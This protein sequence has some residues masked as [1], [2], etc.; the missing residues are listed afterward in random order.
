MT[1]EKASTQLE[2]EVI[3]PLPTGFQRFIPG[4][5]YQCNGV[6]VQLEGYSSFEHADV[7]V[8]TDGSRRRVCIEE[9]AKLT[10]G[11][12]R[13]VDTQAECNAGARVDLEHEPTG[14]EYVQVLTVVH[15]VSA[16]NKYLSLSAIQASAE[17]IGLSSRKL[18]EVVRRY[19]KEGRVYLRLKR[20]RKPGGRHLGAERERI[21]QEVIERVYLAHRQCAISEVHKHVE[22]ECT[23]AGI[24]NVPCVNTIKARINA[25]SPRHVAERRGDLEQLR[26]TRLISGST[27]PENVL[28]IVQIDFTVAD[29]VIVD[30]VYRRPIG[31]PLL[32]LAIECKSRVVV[33]AW[34]FLEAPSHFTSG[35]MIYHSIAPKSLLLESLGCYKEFPWPCF[36]RPRLIFVDNGFKIRELVEACGRRDIDVRFRIPGEVQSGGMIERLIGTFLGK[37]HML[38]GTTYSDPLKRKRAKYD[39]SSEAIYTLREAMQYLV[40][41]VHRYHHAP[42]GGLGKQAPIDVWKAAFCAG[43]SLQPPALPVDPA[44]FFIPFLWREE[45]TVQ[46]EGVLLNRLWYRCDALAPYVEQRFAVYYNRNC[47]KSIYLEVARDQFIEV[48]AIKL[49]EASRSYW[50]SEWLARQAAGGSAAYDPEHRIERAKAVTYQTG[51]EVRAKALTSELRSGKAK[52]D[53]AAPQETD[54]ASEGSEDSFDLT[55]AIEIPAVETWEGP[56]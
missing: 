42:H 36:G 52:T 43:G 44:R 4:G 54:E 21:I 7:L 40:A 23:N 56:L 19:R 55:A 1:D 28:D 34:L 17:S 49:E 48:P 16:T 24:A 20:G 41:E 39:P 3:V 31:R 25:L 51:L 38:H 50:V 13:K 46:R 2:H 22:A 14:D 12:P 32:G 15:E 47:P 11:E 9:L 33:G 10:I 6:A 53:V 18:A 37:I 8:L 5:T 45:R 35:W 26:A 29:L 27:E 30:D